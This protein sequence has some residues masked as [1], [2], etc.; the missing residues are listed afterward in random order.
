MIFPR[1]GKGISKTEKS[2][3]ETDNRSIM[4]NESVERLMDILLQMKINFGH[5][6]NT[7]RQQTVE[8]RQQLAIIFESEKKSL[9]DCLTAI[10]RKLGECAAYVE[11]YRIM[12][13][14]LGSLREKLVQLGAHPTSMPDALPTDQL[15]AIV[16]WRLQELKLAGKI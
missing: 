6:A 5:I 2:A 14:H 12:Y 7:L 16:K 13:T 1:H 11:N 8:I 4:G 3:S 15:N 10:D 9:E